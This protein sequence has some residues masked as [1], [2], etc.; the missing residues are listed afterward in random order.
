MKDREMTR[1]EK[2]AFKVV[3]A[4]APTWQKYHDEMLDNIKS[5]NG[6]K[7]IDHK[8]VMALY[9]GLVETAFEVANKFTEFAG[10]DWEKE[11]DSAHDD[12]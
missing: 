1:T 3:C 7:T 6:V 10:I 12:E 2:L 8:E 11:E 4:L 5:N 9:E